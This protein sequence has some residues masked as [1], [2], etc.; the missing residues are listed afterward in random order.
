MKHHVD[1]H[2]REVGIAAAL[3]LRGGIH[4]QLE[5]CSGQCLVIGIRGFSGHDACYDFV[6]EMTNGFLWI[7]RTD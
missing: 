6:G 1:L 2:G 5:S 4:R 7:M 3:H